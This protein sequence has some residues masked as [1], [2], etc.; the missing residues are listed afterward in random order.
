M[1]QLEAI[2]ELEGKLAEAVSAD[3]IDLVRELDKEL[4]DQFEQVMVYVPTSKT[5]LKDLVSYFLDLLRGD[6]SDGEQFDS[7]RTRIL[8]LLEI[9]STL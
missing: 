9:A 4:A 1:H 3:D 2:K 7:V 8:E 6:F 5:E